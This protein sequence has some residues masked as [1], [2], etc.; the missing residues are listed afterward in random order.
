M[1]LFLAATRG[2]GGAGPLEAGGP[3]SRTLSSPCIQGVVGIGVSLVAGVKHG[4]LG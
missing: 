2:G 3:T 4:F 1:V